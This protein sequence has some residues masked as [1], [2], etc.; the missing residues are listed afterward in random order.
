MNELPADH[1]T[2]RGRDGGQRVTRCRFV[3]TGRVQGV[4]FRAATRAQAEQ[5]GLV[6]FVGNRADGAV[7][8]EAQGEGPE[9]ATLRAW[10]AA[11]PRLAQVLAVEWNEV[12]P[13]EGDAGFRIVR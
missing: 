4:G 3:V 8:G 2:P 11:G 5:L 13:R 6:G 12:A 10:L 7:V 9:L 1:R